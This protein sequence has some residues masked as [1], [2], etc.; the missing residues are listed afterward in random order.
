MDDIQ[1]LTHIWLSKEEALIY[2]F[3]IKNRYQSITDISKNTGLYRYSI[4]KVLP[5]L[6]EYWLVSQTVK[7]KRKLFLAESPDNL[8]NLYEKQ[9]YNYNILLD[10]LKNSYG[11]SD[12]NHVTVK[13]IEWNNF[14]KFVFEDIW[15]SLAKDWVYYRY[16]SKKNLDEKDKLP[17]YKKLRD[18]KCIQRYIITSENLLKNKPKRLD[19]DIVVIPKDYDLFDD[20]ISKVIYKNKI[21]IIDYNTEMAYIFEN[22]K[23]ADFEKKIF[24]LL[25]KSLKKS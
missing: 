12:K 1:V 15:N 7:W 6:Q 14:S 18:K 16:S 21:W 23:L 19:H 5:V 9:T 24:K 22:Q 4:Y 10:K 3:L 13:I 2:S 17:L 20:N 8:N 11:N 25:F